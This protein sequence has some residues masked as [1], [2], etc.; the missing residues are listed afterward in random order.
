MWR[1]AKLAQPPAAVWWNSASSEM[2]TNLLTGEDRDVASFKVNS[3]PAGAWFLMDGWRPPL[4]LENV[5]VVTSAECVDAY[6]LGM[7]SLRSK[8]RTRHF[9]RQNR[10]I[11]LFMPVWSREEL[12][13]CRGLCFPHLTEDEVKDAFDMWCVCCM[14]EVP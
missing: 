2:C 11:R 10:V 5:F 9:L 12:L 3:V 7:I 8:E 14:R 13:A 6:S 1:I 4:G